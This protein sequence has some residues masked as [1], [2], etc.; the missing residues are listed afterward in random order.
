EVIHQKIK[1]AYSHGKLYMSEFLINA[2]TR[3]WVTEGMVN[4]GVLHE[5]KVVASDG[6]IV[7]SEDMNLLFY[8]RNRLIG[9]G[10]EGD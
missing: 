3:T 5:A 7:W 4:L 10:F 1:K 2:D 9:Y 8:Y 6:S